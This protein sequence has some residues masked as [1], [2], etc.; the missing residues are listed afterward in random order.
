MAYGRLVVLQLRFAQEIKREADEQRALRAAGDPIPATARVYA[1]KAGF[2]MTLVSGV[3]CGVLVALSMIS[4]QLH[5]V[6]IV[7]FAAF[8]AAGVAQM[9]TGRHF[10]SGGR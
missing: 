10:V 7:L 3:G 2:G 1:R 6:A 4:G 5:I 9:I 8:A